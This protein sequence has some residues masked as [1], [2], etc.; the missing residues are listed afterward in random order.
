[1]AASLSNFVLSIAAALAGEA[2]VQ[3]GGSNAVLFAFHAVEENAA[4]S[5]YAVLRTYP[6]SRPSP[7]LRRP[8]AS[9]QLMAMAKTDRAAIDL[10]EKFFAL[11]WVS[12]NGGGKHARTM[13]TVP[14]KRISGAGAVETDGTVSYL[15]RYVAP[16]HE[17]GVLGTDEKG[18]RM[19]A[20]NCDVQWEIK[21]V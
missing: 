19:A 16:I 21:S 18:R 10:A 14:G 15:V 3:F 20:F 8:M 5:G 9:L 4:A 1:M 17:P 2:G 7:V 13:W 12:A 6:G 11:L